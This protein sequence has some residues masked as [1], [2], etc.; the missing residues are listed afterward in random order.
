MAL[1][2]IPANLLFRQMST[3]RFISMC[4]RANQET[5]QA[6]S[7]GTK[8]LG[9]SQF[10]R[11]VSAR[12][13]Q[14]WNFKW[15]VRRR[16]QLEDSYLLD[17]IAWVFVAFVEVLLN[18]LLALVAVNRLTHCWTLLWCVYIWGGPAFWQAD[19]SLPEHL[20]ST[21]KTPSLKL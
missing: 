4:T 19:S 12:S 18:R 14:K 21:Q 13:L 7:R 2:N 3:Q 11:R 20:N 10:R 1:G 17:V 8:R 15:T 9:T 5:R 16:V 6:V